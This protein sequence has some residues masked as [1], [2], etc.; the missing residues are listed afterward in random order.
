M[1][2]VSH[3]STSAAEGAKK[4][5]A[6][7]AELS[8]MT[9]SI[10]EVVVSI[11]EIA[12]QTNFLAL[13]ATIEAARAG[14][15]HPPAPPSKGGMID[16]NFWLAFLPALFFLIHPLQTEAIAYTAGRADPLSAL[17][18]LLSLIFYFNLQ[19]SLNC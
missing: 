15:N 11:R 2:E 9:E 8:T 12:E 14:H 6:T 18:C 4:A 5:S 3:K 10:G 16:C 7:V 17:F 19:A 1:H 13:N